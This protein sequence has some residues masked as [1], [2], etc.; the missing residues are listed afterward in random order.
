MATLKLTGSVG[1]GKSENGI[2]HNEV[3]DVIKVRDRFVELG[4]HWVGSV[5]DGKNTDFVRLIKFFQTITKGHS[6]F[7]TGDGRIDLGGTTHK[8]L[9]AVNAPGW[10]N[11]LGKTGIGWQ[12]AKFDHGNSWTTSWMLDR[13]V[14][15]GLLYR[16]MAAIAIDVSDAPSMWVRDCSPEKGGRATGHG[17]HQTGLDMD[18]R[19]PLLPPD[20]DKFDQ[21]FGQD[22]NKRF[23][24]KAAFLQVRAIKKMMDTKFIFFNDPEFIKERLTSHEDNH[25]EHYH[26]R[27]KPPERIEGVI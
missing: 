22:Y 13:L 6:K 15:A 4:Y 9:A 10:V 1:S 12:I 20:T 27:I 14:L 8:W 7:D 17:S 25:S 26:I 24:R 5:T 11:M 2:S 18:M 3:A 21:L 23:H 16:G 19:L